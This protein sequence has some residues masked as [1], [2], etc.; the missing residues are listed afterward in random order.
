MDPLV[1]DKIF[2]P[3]FTDK[4]AK[5]GTGLGL[6]VSYRLIQDHQGEIR[7]E[8]NPDQG[9]T[10]TVSMPTGFEPK[11]A[12]I[13]VVD[14]DPHLQKAIVRTLKRN[15]TYVIETAGTGTEA[16]IRMGTF[17]PDLMILDV[18]MPEMNGVEVCRAIQQMPA[19]V[20]DSRRVMPLVEAHRFD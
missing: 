13:L 6:S 2:D 11:S 14:D 16:L 10:F 17:R 5:G 4:Q 3:F 12:R 20:S 8:N 7:F 18:C 1:A 19:L 9:V 15:R